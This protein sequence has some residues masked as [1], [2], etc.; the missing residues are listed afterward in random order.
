MDRNNK[1]EDARREYLG[2][3]LASVRAYEAWR[4]TGHA[5]GPEKDAA[6]EAARLVEEAH[7]RYGAAV[8]LSRR[9]ENRP[10]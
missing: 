7:K 10:G 1:I 5:E 8:D 3:S 2:A 6:L 4:D 9:G